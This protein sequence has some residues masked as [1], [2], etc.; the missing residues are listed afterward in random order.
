MIPFIDVILKTLGEFKG[1]GTFQCLTIFP[2][3]TFQALYQ[4]GCV[5]LGADG[6]L[7]K[8]IDTAKE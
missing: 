8:Q 4:H 2:N 1:L 3:G 5:R 6:K 7:V